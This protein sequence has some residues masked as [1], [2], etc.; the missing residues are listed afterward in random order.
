V[1]V[2]ISREEQLG[3]LLKALHQSTPDVEGAAVISMDGLVMASSLPA[4]AD[5]DR[6]SAMSAAIYGIGARTAAELERGAVEQLYIK[7]E[8]GYF[9][10]TQTGPDAMLAVMAS[11]QAKLGIIFLDVKRTAEQIARLV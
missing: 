9:L 1:T 6:V 8:N 10:I 7:G 2:T 4:S 3:Q 5:E 11:S